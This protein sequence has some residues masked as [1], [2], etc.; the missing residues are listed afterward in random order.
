MA[1]KFDFKYGFQKDLLKDMQ[2]YKTDF[3][4]RF[5][6]TWKQANQR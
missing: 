4:K 2:E 6:V 1:K 3:K 5:G